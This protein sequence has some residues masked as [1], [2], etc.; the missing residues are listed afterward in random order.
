MIFRSSRKPFDLEE[1]IIQDLYF[2]NLM[3]KLS[4]KDLEFDLKSLRLKDSKSSYYN[5]AAYVFSEQ[6]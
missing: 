2:T 1:S 5:N 4:E 3:N 6:N